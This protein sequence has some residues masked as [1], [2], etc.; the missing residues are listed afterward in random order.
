MDPDKKVAVTDLSEQ[1]W[2]RIERRLFERVAHGEA[3]L[4]TPRS[5][6]EASPR[7]RMAGALVLAGA[8]A[9]I[10]GGVAWRA[11]TGPAA[12]AVVPS[13]IATESTGSHVSVGEATLDIAPQSVV[14]V[15]G[16]DMNGVTVTLEHGRVECEVPPRHGRPPFSVQAG[17]VSVRVVGTHFAVSREAATVDVNVQ[18]GVVAVTANG[19]ETAV[20]A[21]EQWPPAVMVAESAAPSAVPQM[22]PAAPSGNVAPMPSAAPAS[23]S[24]P[25]SPRELYE[26]ATRLEA[27]RPDL[28]V[29]KYRALATKGGPWGTNA[30]F[31]QGRLESER[32][33]VGE[34]R[35]LLE[36][37]LARYPSGPNAGDARQLL[38]RL[39]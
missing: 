31:A 21:G 29:A 16:D 28:A 38:S 15:S 35:L 7:F 22:A 8:V 6:V 30:L 37:Y 23:S 11:L 24:P 25:P 5:R 26:A 18:R 1:R 19:Q 34:A 13:R 27:A 20:H 2:M 36:D 39:R 10:G 4:S 3:D 33:H 32:G 9:A 14:A 17:A 12:Q